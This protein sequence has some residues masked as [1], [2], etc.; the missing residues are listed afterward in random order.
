M[1]GIWDKVSKGAVDASKAAYESGKGAVAE[2]RRKS[3]TKRLTE[4]IALGE[5]SGY[6]LSNWPEDLSALN[7]EELNA[8]VP[9]NEMDDALYAANLRL[10]KANSDAAEAAEAARVFEETSAWAERMFNNPAALLAVEI[11]NHISKSNLKIV[12][13]KYTDQLAGQQKG[14]NTSSAGSI[15]GGL[16]A[17]GITSANRA[18]VATAIDLGVPNGRVQRPLAAFTDQERAV[19]QAAAILRAHSRYPK[20]TFEN[21][22]LALAW[23]EGRGFIEAGVGD[24]LEGAVQS[25]ARELLDAAFPANANMV[26][27]LLG[28][29]QAIMENEDG[30]VSDAL[31][32]A[33]TRGQRWGEFAD[34]PEHRLRPWQEGDL[35]LGAFETGGALGFSGNESLVTFGPPGR[36][37]SQAHALLNLLAYPGP[38]IALDL[39]GELFRDSAGYR[40]Q[41]F[42][43]RVLK[44]SLMS[45][46]APYHRFNPLLM[47]SREPDFLWDDA[48][49]MAI[50]LLPSAPGESDP[51]WTNSA[52]DLVAVLIGSM[53]IGC[54]DEETTFAE[55][56]TRMAISGDDRTEFLEAVAKRALDAGVPGLRNRANALLGLK[57]SERAMENIYQH[58]RQALSCFESPIV[59]RATAAMDWRPEDLR[60]GATTLYLSLPMDQIE[61]YGPVIRAVIGAHI[62]ALTKTDPD[63]TALPVTFL[64]DE[65][66]Q[67]GNFDA[68]VRAVEIGRSY[69]LRLWGFAQHAQQFEETFSRW[70]V[71]TDSPAARCYMNAD[72]ASADV[73]SRTLGEVVDLFTGRET[74]LASPAELMGANY[75]NKIIVMQA[76]GHVHAVNKLMAFEAL[77]DRIALP[78]HF[79]PSGVAQPENALSDLNAESMG[80][81]EV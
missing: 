46:G 4:L 29:Y 48:R 25:A 9:I 44:F 33:F 1:A 6:D 78:Y 52:R 16:L 36:G 45:D 18:S 79:T 53:L 30:P 39:K 20:E 5:H 17:T 34:L 49:A 26:P 59:Q 13:D 42:G 32:D 68:V 22:K 64:L 41:G 55:L 56:M 51:Y 77:P 65:L 57:K 43:A 40:Q 28:E 8:L 69:G 10:Q 72:L 70:K 19:L 67:L 7:Q 58:A 31:R 15:A 21:I 63:P 27:R 11:G 66:P 61:P 24:K 50:D 23:G 54:E 75:E 12:R 2:Q 35:V 60:T 3:H 47:L 74:L 14:V 73:I 71:L 81:A 76:G 62:K 38:M 37:K 80:E